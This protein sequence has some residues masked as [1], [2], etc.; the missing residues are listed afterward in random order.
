[1][2]HDNCLAL[3]FT[4]EKWKQNEKDK[5]LELFLSPSNRVLNI[6]KDFISGSKG[7]KKSSD[8]KLNF[9]HYFE[10]TIII[11]SLRFF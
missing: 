4:F 11:I 8:V 1:M 9:E 10:D 2:Q 6:A 7:Y 3:E 5:M